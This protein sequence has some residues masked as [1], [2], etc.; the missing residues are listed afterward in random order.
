MSNTIPLLYTLANKSKSFSKIT[1]SNFKRSEVLTQLRKS[2]QFSQIEDAA[3][4]TTE[5]HC[6]GSLKQLFVDFVM[7]Y[8]QKINI[9]NPNLPYFLYKKIIQF[10]KIT[11]TY[12]KLI[13]TRNN[14]EI[15]NM[16]ADIVV[17]LATS[18]KNSY[19]NSLP[20]PKAEDY[21]PINLRKKVISKNTAILNGLMVD[22]EP[23]EVQ[24]AIAEIATHLTIAT[25]IHEPIFWY[26]W[27]RKKFKQA[28]IYI[29]RV[30]NRR[31]KQLSHKHQLAIKCLYEIF[32]RYKKQDA[33][34]CSIA[35]LKLPIDWNIPLFRKY[36]IR[37]QVCGN[38]NQIYRYIAQKTNDMSLEEFKQIKVYNEGKLKKK[39]E[40]EKNI[41]IAAATKYL[42]VVPFTENE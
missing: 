21:V 7:A 11:D 32:R 4:W 14:Q 28:D 30:L 15:R 12:N 33:I 16:F 34:Y 38:I 26:K 36:S 29:W 40:K 8:V 10:E 41:Q 27:L 39:H 9:S 6:S 5:L 3:L 25:P 2:I 37:I 23:T 18:R 42:D 17:C 13:D 22:T 20:V 1:I 19:L 24:L 31:S 35:F